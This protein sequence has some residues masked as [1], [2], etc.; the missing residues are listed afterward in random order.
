M[1]EIK[2]L[3]LSLGDVQVFKDFDLTVSDGEFVAILGLSGC[4]KSTL[5]KAICGFTE[6]Q[7]GSIYLDGSCIDTVPPHKRGMTLVFQ[8]LRLFPHMKLWENVAFP[9]KMQGIKKQE[10]RER[11]MELLSLVDLNG[12]ES[13]KPAEI[14]GGQQQRVAL[15]RALAMKPR[16]LLMDEPFS[17]LDDD[18]RMEMQALLKNL[19]KKTKPSVLFVT[20]QREEARILSTRIVELCGK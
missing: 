14:S 15:V 20:H 4:G 5:L 12:L 19:H 11:A 7:G 8:D 16:I 13:R 9:L 18:T 6:Y 10:R 2:K 3:N 17:G 1:L